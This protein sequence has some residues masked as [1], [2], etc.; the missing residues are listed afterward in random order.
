MK[1]SSTIW[2]HLSNCF[3]CYKKSRGSQ[4]WSADTKDDAKHSVNYI[5]D[6][7]IKFVTAI[8]SNF[9]TP[10]IEQATDNSPLN[11]LGDFQCQ[12]ITSSDIARAINSLSSSA[13]VGVDG[14]KVSELKHLVTKSV[15]P[16]PTFLINH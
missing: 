4:P 6:A 13:N 10:Q 9:S 14:I 3:G 16:S 2:K 12:E 7:F 11:A 1:P 8:T 5:N 15:P